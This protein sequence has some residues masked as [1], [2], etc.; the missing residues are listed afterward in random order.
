MTKLL[1]WVLEEEEEDEFPDEVMSQIIKV[2][3]GSPGEALVLLDAVIDLPVDGMKE[4]VGKVQARKRTTI[5]LIH[6][7]MQG[8][9]WEKVRTLLAEL[10]GEQ[11][12]RIRRAILTYI[13]KV[14]LNDKDAGGILL[15]LY[16]AFRDPFFNTGRAGLVFAC[17]EILGKEDDIP[18]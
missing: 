2:A 7:L 1:D 13:T 4:A 14:A 5:E 9:P 12:E 18:F 17:L 15:R 3:D 16:D 11:E 8:Q 6:A 10:E